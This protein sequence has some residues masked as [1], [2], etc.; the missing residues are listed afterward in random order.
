MLWATPSDPRRAGGGDEVPR[1]LDP[2]PG[3]RGQVPPGEVRQ[4]VDDD[5]GP[6]GPHR[7]ED[8]GPVEGIQDNRA[9]PQPAPQARLRRV[10]GRADD[11]VPLGNEERQ[12]PTTNHTGRA[13]DEDVHV[14]PPRARV[15]IPARPTAAKRPSTGRW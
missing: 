9:R 15:S 11:L 5:L 1:S 12:Q 10:A 14:C 4:L 8:A 2:Q 7:R 6:L 13:G 3:V